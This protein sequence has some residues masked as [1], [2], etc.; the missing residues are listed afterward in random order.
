MDVFYDDVI[1]AGSTLRNYY[2]FNSN[3][4]R[5]IMYD[6]IPLDID[7]KN[8]IFWKGAPLKND[9]CMGVLYV[10]L[11]EVKKHNNEFYNKLMNDKNTNINMFIILMDNNIGRIFPELGEY[12]NELAMEQARKMNS[13]SY[14]EYYNKKKN[15]IFNH[16]FK[17]KARGI[18][19][20]LFLDWMIE[21]REYKR[22]KINKDFREQYPDYITLSDFVLK[23]INEY[24]ALIDTYHNKIF[25]QITNDILVR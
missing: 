13:S 17:L 12:Y 16:L 2:R 15:N 14:I 23:I 10:K 18:N 19:T 3:T 11:L 25:K 4:L 8:Y 20:F 22:E 21:I 9:T 1:V 6:K 7:I 24:R 5:D